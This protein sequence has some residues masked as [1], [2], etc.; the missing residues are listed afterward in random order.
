MEVASSTKARPA[1]I[2][3]IPQTFLNTG[4]SWCI[5]AVL[6][7][8]TT[9]V[10]NRVVWHQHHP[11]AKK[12]P[13]ARTG[14]YFHS[15]GRQ[16]FA[17]PHGLLAFDIDSI[18]TCG[19]N[20]D[21]RHCQQANCSE[22]HEQSTLRMISQARKHGWAVG[23]NTARLFVQWDFV[24]R[25][26]QAALMRSPYCHRPNRSYPIARHKVQCMRELHAELAP[27]TQL[28]NAILVD[29]QEYNLQAVRAAGMRTIRVAHAPP[30]TQVATALWRQ[31]IGSMDIVA[32][33]I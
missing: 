23:L 25:S 29:D 3:W 21:C 14:K 24:P 33:I 27:H 22:S 32:I 5:V 15:S 9:L 26:I 10:L 18:L 7:L 1:T 31:Q 6:L 30:K 20:L 12:L 2:S 13:R 28:L 17:C 19:A 8:A 11:H 16:D 4:R